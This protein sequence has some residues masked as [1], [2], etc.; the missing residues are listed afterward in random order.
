MTESAAL[1][2]VSNQLAERY[3]A[4]GET[5]ADRLRAWLNGVA[6]MGFP[7][8]LARHLDAAHVPLLFDAF[9]QVLP[10]GTVDVAGALVTDR[11][12]SIMRLPP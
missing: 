3:G 8:V 6:P 12:A 5:A 7:E 9:W 2:E 11:T 1:T 4:Q 10:F